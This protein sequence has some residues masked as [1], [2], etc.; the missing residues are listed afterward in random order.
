MIIIIVMTICI[1]YKKVE[2]YTLHKL[3]LLMNHTCIQIAHHNFVEA[4]DCLEVSQ[5]KFTHKNIFM[6]SNTQPI[7]ISN[8][9][10]IM[11][12]II[13]YSEIVGPKVL[14][15]HNKLRN[16]FIVYHKSND[17]ITQKNSC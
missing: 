2:S 15:L 16:G 13:C 17:I 5:S 7:N 10:Q 12:Y 11:C 4:K 6:G 9:N 3:F 14:A 1:Y 8:Y